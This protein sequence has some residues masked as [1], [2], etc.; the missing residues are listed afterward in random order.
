MIKRAI[1][2]IPLLALLLCP[3]PLPAQKATTQSEFKNLV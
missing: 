1:P 2:V 3:A